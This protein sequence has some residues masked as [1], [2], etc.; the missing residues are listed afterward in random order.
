MARMAIGGDGF[1]AVADPARRS[2]LEFVAGR[3]RTVGEIVVHLRLAQPSVSKHL[4]VLHGA[5]LVRSR[6]AGRSVLY[7]ANGEAIR[8]LH[9][10][11][12][13]FERLWQRQ[14]D[15]VKRRAE[16]AATPD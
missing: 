11:T 14:L 12:G 3:E 6:R 9:A 10:W 4:G 7:C 1:R 13:R 16:A 2:I 15:G 5:G 8:P